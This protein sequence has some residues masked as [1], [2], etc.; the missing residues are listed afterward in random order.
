MPIPF[1]PARLPSTFFFVS[2]ISLTVKPFVTRPNSTVEEIADIGKLAK[3]L[4]VK[5]FFC[6]LCNV[7]PISDVGLL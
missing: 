6:N 3:V 4:R 2:N 5:K 1:N 7:L